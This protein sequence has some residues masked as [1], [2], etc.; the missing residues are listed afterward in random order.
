MDRPGCRTRFLVLGSAAPDLVRGVSETLAGR[1]E[2]IEM[3]GFGLDETGAPQWR[4]F[5]V[6]GGFPMRS[7]SP[8]F[9]LLALT[10]CAPD[11]PPVPAMTTEPEAVEAEPGVAWIKTDMGTREEREARAPY[12]PWWWPVNVG[13]TFADTSTYSYF[14]LS[15]AG[16][17]NEISGVFWVDTLAFEAVF[18]ASDTEWPPNGRPAPLEW[19]YEG[20]FPRKSRRSPEEWGHDWPTHLEDSDSADVA[21]W[22]SD[23]QP[24]NG[25]GRSPEDPLPGDEMW[26]RERW[27]EGWRGPGTEN[28]Q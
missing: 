8:L 19:V 6:R 1:V 7:A 27:L 13:Y 12:S 14:D 23:P 22:L 21:R 25:L 4:D 24:R 3:S 16:R 5:W 10:D 28:D 17:W 15:A 2:L 26:T 18:T 11:P 20:H 9:V